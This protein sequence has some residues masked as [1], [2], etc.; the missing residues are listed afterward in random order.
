MVCF[1]GKG[2]GLL[3][4]K[5]FASNRSIQSGTF[6]ITDALWY[7]VGTDTKYKNW[8]E[9]LRLN[10]TRD[11]FTT[12]TSTTPTSTS[13]HILNPNITDD[14]C[15]EFDLNVNYD[16][17][18]FRIRNSTTSLETYSTS[19]MGLT[20][21]QWSHISIK[22]IDSKLTVIVDGDII[23]DNKSISEWDNFCFMIPSNSNGTIKYKEFYYYP[24][25]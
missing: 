24:I 7:D 21:N 23:T 13:Y 4:I 18:V 6:A 25:G 9:D 1:T 19:N 3:N 8:N 11:T 2:A 22:I 16:S 15:I 12:L 10:I 14:M 20:L 5:A 17:N